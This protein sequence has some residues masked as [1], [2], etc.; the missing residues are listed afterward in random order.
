MFNIRFNVQHA[1]P[2]LN[3]RKPG[4]AEV[5]KPHKQSALCLIALAPLITLMSLTLHATDYLIKP[6]FFYH[7]LMQENV[8]LKQT[9][10]Y[11]SL[12]SLNKEALAHIPFPL[13]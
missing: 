8:T 11:C 13:M 2:D 3:P 12:F 6:F 10:Q 5:V 9:K 1:R 7:F 4:G